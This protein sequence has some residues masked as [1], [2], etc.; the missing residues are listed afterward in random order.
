MVPTAKGDTRI[1]YNKH[2]IALGTSGYNFAWFYPRKKI[3]HSHMNIKVGIDNRP[4]LLKKLEDAGIEAENHRRDQI[5]VHLSTKD[6][7]EHRPFIV[8]V[9]Q[10]PKNFRTDNR[11]Y[12]LPAITLAHRARCA[13]A[14]DTL[15]ISTSV[16]RHIAFLRHSPSLRATTVFHGSKQ[17]SPAHLRFSGLCDGRTG[18]LRFQSK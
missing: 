16:G 9:Q 11:R 17:H 12:F 5:R 14:R 2:H 4:E 15:P 13:V 8:E 18:V 10:L 3:A 1:T 7:Q 6:I